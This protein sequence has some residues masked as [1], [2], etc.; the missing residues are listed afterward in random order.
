MFDMFEN[1]LEA[2]LSCFLALVMD[3]LSSIFQ[4]IALLYTVKMCLQIPG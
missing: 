2:S 1:F 4:I 3:T